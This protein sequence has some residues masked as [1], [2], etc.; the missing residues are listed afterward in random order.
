[1][2]L[3]ELLISYQQLLCFLER[4][5][6]VESIEATLYPIVSDINTFYLSNFILVFLLIGVGLWYSIKTRFV[7]LSLLLRGKE[8]RVRQP[9]A[10]RQKHDS[11]MSLVPGARHR[12]RRSGRYGQHR[13]R[14]RRDPLTGGPGAI[15]LIVWP[16]AFSAYYTSRGSDRPG[17]PARRK[18]MARSRAAPCTITAPLRG[19]G[20]FSA[21]FADAS[22][23]RSASAAWCSP[24]PTRF[25]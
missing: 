24:I 21:G 9:V 12:H 17:R 11:G 19:F 2:L 5:N 18:G 14:V 1:M 8:Q 25:D 15:F 10:A 22:R 7:Q 4:V 13:R 3:P 23:W 20:K 16:I 6:H